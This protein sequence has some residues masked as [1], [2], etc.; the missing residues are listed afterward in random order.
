LFQVAMFTW[1]NC[2]LVKA[3][4]TSIMGVQQ[5]GEFTNR[6]GETSKLGW[7]GFISLFRGVVFT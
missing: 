2:G 1:F 6:V 5:I 4:N 3:V 7:A